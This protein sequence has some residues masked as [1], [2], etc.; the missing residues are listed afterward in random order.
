MIS[1]IVCCRS[2]ELFKGLSENIQETIGCLYELIG[3]VNK[4][5]QHGICAAYNSGI[6]K[7]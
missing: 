4:K 3:I 7:A 6:K 5:N 1:I 2:L